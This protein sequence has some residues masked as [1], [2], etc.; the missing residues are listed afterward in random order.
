[1]LAPPQVQVLA[2]RPIFVYFPRRSAEGQTWAVSAWRH[3]PLLGEENF[4][5][6]SSVHLAMVGDEPAA[7]APS[8]PSFLIT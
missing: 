6:R 2:P 7:V 3:E 1:M 8:W 4:P 5:E